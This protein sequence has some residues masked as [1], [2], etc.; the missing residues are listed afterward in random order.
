MAIVIAYTFRGSIRL[1][2][3]AVAARGCGAGGEGATL[4][5]I[6]LVIG[7]PNCQIKYNNNIAMKNR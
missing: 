3:N 7:T 5:I 6:P 2:L 4:N 1:S